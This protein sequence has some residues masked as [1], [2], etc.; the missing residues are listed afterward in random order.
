[1]F[2]RALFAF[3]ALPGVIAFA[4]PF[5]LANA[6]G[7]EPRVGLVGVALFLAGGVG[8][9][10]CVRDFHVVG[11]GTLAPWAPPERLVVVGLYRWT[12]N[13]MYVSV[14]LLLAGW[15][16]TY[17]TP[18]LVAYALLVALGFHLRVVRAEEPFQT[19]RYGEA[20]RAYAREVPR[21]L[22]R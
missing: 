14:L 2:A 9:L 16:A 19:R 12:R 11:K 22:W 13:P 15:A 20:W 18:V 10:W 3:L 4:L 8:L 7:A 5:L 6:S 17:R 21:W 1:V